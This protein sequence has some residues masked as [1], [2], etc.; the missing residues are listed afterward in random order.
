MPSNPTSS[1]S[2]AQN[3]DIA[4]ARDI[5]AVIHR[6]M[7]AILAEKSLKRKCLSKLKIQSQQ[8]FEFSD[9]SVLSNL[10]WG[11]ENAAEAAALLGSLS[12]DERESRLDASE[13]M[14][15]IPASLD[16][17]GATLGI[18]NDRLVCS[19]YLCLAAVEFLR[20]NEWRAAAHFLQAV[21]ICPGIVRRDFAPGIWREVAPLF[22]RRGV[23]ESLGLSA[24]LDEFDDGMIDDAMRWMAGRYKPWLMYYQIMS[25]GDSCRSDAVSTPLSGV[26]NLYEQ[27]NGVRTN[28]NRPITRQESIV[29][30]DVDE[31]PVVSRAPTS[32]IKCLKDILT[33][34]QP[35]TP[36]S[37]CLDDISDNISSNEDT[38]VESC[39]ED[40]EGEDFNPI[41]SLSWNARRPSGQTWL[42]RTQSLQTQRQNDGST[43]ESIY[44]SFSTSFCDTDLRTALGL[45]SRCHYA[46]DFSRRA[47]SLS[48]RATQQQEETSLIEQNGVIERIILKLCFAEDLEKT[49][50]NY[51]VDMNTIYDVL[52]TKTGLKYSLL[53]DM[54][55]DELLIAI[56]TSEEEIVVRTS[57]GILSTIITSNRSVA[58]DVQRRGLRLH[59]LAAA[60]KRHVHEAAVLIHLINP[61]PAEVRELEL[62]PCLVEVVCTQTT[63][64]SHKE[65]A[66]E[67]VITPP[68]ASLMIIEM[69]VTAFDLET[70]SAH[71]AAITPPRV[72][73]ALLRAPRRGHL[74]EVASLACVLAKS[75]CIDD[76]CRKYIS[77][78]SHDTAPFVSLLWSNQEQAAS[79]ALEFF[80]ELLKTPRSSAIAL[81]EEMQE[82]GSSNNLCALFL[83]T[84]NST[85]EYRILA[86][87]LLL[88]LEV[89]EDAST[90]SMYR[91]EAA[92]ALFNA[93]QREES[94]QTQALSSFILANLGGTFS[95]TGEA[96]T[97]AWLVKKTGLNLSQ[98]RNLIKTYDFLDESLQDSGVDSWCSKI[99][100]RILQLGTRV[101]EALDKGM[102]SKT[103]RVS[104]DSLVATAWL[105]L[106]LMKGQDELRHAACEILLHSVEQF[107][108]P[109]FELEER[110][111]ACLCIYNYTSGRGMKRII[112][113]SEGVRESLRRLSN[114]TWMAE[115]LL[116]VAD[117]F[118]PNKWRI[119]CV[120]SQI[121]EAGTTKC[122]AAV[123]ALIYYKG[124]LCSGYADGSIKAWE[125]R[126]QTATLVVERKEHRKAVT[127]LALYDL[128][129]CLLSCSADKTIKMWHMQQ[130]NL[131]CIE[132]IPTKE[133]LR[134]IDSLGELMFV[135]TQS[136]KLKVIDA[137]RKPR[138]VLK[139]KRVKCMRV[140]QGKVYTGCMDSSIVE[141]V[142]I[143][144]RQQ[145]MKEP[146]K[147]WMQN[148]PIRSISLYKDWL[149]GASLAVEGAKMKEWRRSSRPQMSLVPE[150]GASILAMEVVEDFIYLNCST[151]MSSLQIWLRGTQQKVGRLSAGSKIT[152]LLSANDMILCGTEKGV[153]K[154]WIPL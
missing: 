52:S 144:N 77:Q 123:T 48:S 42:E 37:S 81:L 129:N 45:R 9:H 12:A 147:S 76:K 25:A 19:S 11:V 41:A 93:L 49:E 60:L 103:R 125:V 10:Y 135:T 43:A 36:K 128:G 97:M 58:V 32:N 20:G 146:S 107:V 7:H 18:P 39:I 54:I 5:A 141:V 46:H 6:H 149:Y 133:S 89:L 29:A 67:G 74:D 136:H 66:E 140:A 114:V 101:F 120:H 110:L 154:G 53:K 47:K 70:N 2:A 152:S 84:Q 3:P 118:Q 88:Q 83:L 16:G 30:D 151:S 4:A 22:V 112:N 117:Y 44:R 28:P 87:N 94:P 24:P 90:K 73:S 98:H 86:A 109:G 102:R 59:D 61:A 99:A 116:K 91:E 127:C 126:G 105:G 65:E 134:S 57:L 148:K 14:L 121:L 132:V 1:S 92:E 108:H 113:L 82:Q 78:I 62:L 63:S 138:D 111:V 35:D 31:L 23:R 27:R 150:K 51:T 95:W 64:T 79:A 15:Q 75:M 69:L 55:L 122:S 106:E 80:N 139:N 145:E 100:Q 68:A 21:S 71:L 38:S 143:N 124:Y 115:E 26:Q 153:I 56:S 40:Q 104:R 85:P 119:S 142:I 137:S 50:V 17:G 8:F 34:S 96:Y 130:R 33:E 131:E 13:K 72:I